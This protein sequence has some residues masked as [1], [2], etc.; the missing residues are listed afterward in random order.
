M[1]TARLTDNFKD[2]SSD[3]TPLGVWATLSSLDKRLKDILNAMG[4]KSDEFVLSVERICGTC[5]Y[6]S[7]H[8]PDY[9][10]T[11][12]E[13]GE[14]RFSRLTPEHRKSDSICCHWE[15]A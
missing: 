2:V 3:T 11:V 8:S 5:L 7:P 9:T 10:F 14:C 6:Y 4:K 1:R 13:L 15:S 12:P